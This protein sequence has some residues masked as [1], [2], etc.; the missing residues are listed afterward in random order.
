MKRVTLAL[1][2]LAP[3]GCN[4][5]QSATKVAAADPAFDKAWSSLAQ[6]GAEP[7]FIEGELHGAGLMGEVRRA[8]EPS[9]MDKSP[10]ATELK[11]PLPD[12]E[13]VRVIKA[14]LGAVKGC[15]QVEERNGTVG[16]GKAIVSL[17]IDASG[18]VKDVKVDAPA[19]SASHLPT[20]VGAR[21]R[22]WTF[23][24]FTEGPKKFAYPFV[25]VGG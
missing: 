3:F 5:D 2:L 11:G 16:S 6:G 23:P 20:C 19:F 4:K 12:M 13:V 1:F 9:G 25:F 22:G 7:V 14:N 17:E 24:K 21:A 10:I 15:Y 18:S 8:V